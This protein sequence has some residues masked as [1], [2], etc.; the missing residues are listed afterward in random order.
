MPDSRASLLFNCDQLSLFVRSSTIPNAGMGLFTRDAYIA[1]GKSATRVI[2]YLYGILRSKSHY[3]SLKLHHRRADATELE[4]VEDLAR[5]IHRVYD[6]GTTLSDA[7]HSYYLLISRSCPIGVM[8]DRRSTDSR[9]FNQTARITT[10][11]EYSERDGVMAWNTFAVTIPNVSMPA[12]TELYL[13]YGWK[14]EDWENA[15]DAMNSAVIADRRRPIA[16]RQEMMVKQWQNV[17]SFVHRPEIV[18]ELRSFR[19]SLFNGPPSIDSIVDSEHLKLT[20]SAVLPGLLGVVI[21]KK[22]K[23]EL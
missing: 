1:T 8:N 7:E 18:R 14:D 13:D 3:Q 15:E 10:P 4:Y 22:F 11:T 2:G 19:Y 17:L 5:G 23:N 16:N 20:N 21:T 6:I 9:W 12:N